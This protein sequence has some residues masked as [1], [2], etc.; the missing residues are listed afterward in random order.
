MT[1]MGVVDIHHHMLRSTTSGIRIGL[2]MCK[3]TLARETGGT[4]ET[5]QTRRGPNLC[6][7]RQFRITR[8]S[9]VTV[10]GGRRTFSASCSIWR[11]RIAFQS[12]AEVF[13][14]A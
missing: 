10:R 3:T 6:M 12:G 5:G 14:N 1:Q 13:L 4:S 9:R 7:S 2:E 11:L 8:A